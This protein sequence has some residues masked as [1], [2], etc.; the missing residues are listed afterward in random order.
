MSGSSARIY[1]REDKP[2]Y[3]T[4]SQRGDIHGRKGS[5]RRRRNGS[6]HET[7][8]KRLLRR[9]GRKC[10]AGGPQGCGDRLFHGGAGLRGLRLRGFHLRPGRDLWHGPDRHPG[11]E[12]Q[13]QLRHRID[14]PVP[15]PPGGGMRGGGMRVGPGV[16]T[17]DPGGADGEMVRSSHAPE[18]VHRDHASS[19]PVGGCPPDGPT[20][21]RRRGARVPGKVRGRAR[22][23]RQDLEQGPQA[24]GQQ[25]VR[26]LQATRHRGGGPRLADGRRTADPPPMLPAHVR[27]GGRGP[28]FPGVRREAQSGRPRRRPGPG[29]DHRPARLLRR[30]PD[31][32]HRLR[33]EPRGLH[34]GLRHGGRRAGGR[35]TW[36]SSTTASR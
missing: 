15:G 4:R 10:R 9:H 22:S 13:Q 11:R 25:S 30:Q 32:R 29:D 1:F 35:S 16:R 23:L 20:A 6:V 18:P 33:H 8:E 2:G 24:R 26:H 17:D 12:R 7:R 5:R 31:A 21:L 34:K 19:R 27:R 36:S 14:G 28:L 3:S